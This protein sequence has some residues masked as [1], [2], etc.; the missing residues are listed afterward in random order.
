MR[1]DVADATQAQF[2]EHIPII[3]KENND[4]NQEGLEGVHMS[5]ELGTMKPHVH[6]TAV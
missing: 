5:I 1:S 2:T 3:P 6:G 4:I